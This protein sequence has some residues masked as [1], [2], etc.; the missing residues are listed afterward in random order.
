MLKANSDYLAKQAPP[1]QFS[2]TKDADGIVYRYITD[3]GFQFHPIADFGRL[4]TLARRGRSEAVRRLADALV[5][6]GIRSRKALVWEYY[7]PFGG[8]NRWG[9]GFA[10]AVG[11]QAL[12]Q[13][14]ALLHD[15][16]LEEQARAAFRG[17]SRGLWLELGGG[18]WVREYGF[19]DM[20]ILN[21]Q[22]QSLV[23]LYHYV[24]LTGDDLARAAVAKMASATQTLLAQFDTGCWSRYSLGGSP[25][26]LHYHTYHVQLLKELAA[27]TGDPLW[28]TTAARWDGYLQTGGPTAC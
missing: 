15:P 21:A 7:F 3:H 14:S 16:K 10:Q 26:S 17:I 13:S 1:T 27:K 20:G 11:A 6:R 8:P 23:S 2:D 4:N 5:A 22:L 18:L 9:S 19:S 25:A 28:S 24:E 12:A